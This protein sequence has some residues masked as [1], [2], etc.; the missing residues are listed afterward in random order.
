MEQPHTSAYQLIHLAIQTT[1][2]S[3]ID[4]QIKNLLAPDQD[5]TAKCYTCARCLECVPLEDLPAKE[6]QLK[7]KQ[8][9]QNTLKAHVSLG[10]DH[11]NT[12]RVIV[13]LPLSHAQAEQLLPGSNRK[14]VLQELDRKLEKLDPLMKNQIVQEFNKLVDLG[15]FVQRENLPQSIQQKIINNDLKIYD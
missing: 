11:N 13:S 10:T 5:H 4:I 9:E 1:T 15:F 3:A 7:K 14:S 6:Q 8:L 12:K 2:Q